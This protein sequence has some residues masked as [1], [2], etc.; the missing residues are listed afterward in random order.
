MMACTPCTR[1]WHD[2]ATRLRVRGRWA[3][4]SAFRL[5]LKFPERADD[6]SIDHGVRSG[7]YPLAR[8]ERGRYTHGQARQ[9]QSVRGQTRPDG[10]R[11]DGW[12]SCAACVVGRF[13]TVVGRRS[14]RG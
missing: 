7:G 4:G 6:P 8:P 13:A 12:I 5:G 14:C 2:G 1:C 11:C 10:A 3:D 9:G